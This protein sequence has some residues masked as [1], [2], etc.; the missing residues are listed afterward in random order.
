MAMFYKTVLSIRLP[1]F[2]SPNKSFHITA[3]SMKVMPGSKIPR[4]SHQ[5]PEK[6]G[7]KLFTTSKFR[8]CHFLSVRSAM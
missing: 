7:L 8:G 5:E 2:T 1:H 3:T 4:M 6:I